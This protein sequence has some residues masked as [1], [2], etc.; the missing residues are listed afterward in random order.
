MGSMVH[1]APGAAPFDTNRACCRI[2]ADAFHWRKIDYQAAV[3]GAQARAIVSAAADRQ[4]Q[5]LLACKVDGGDYI[6]DIHAAH[7]QRGM[8]INH[9]VV[10]LACLLVG[11]IARTEQGATQMSCQFLDRLL[12]QSGCD[13]L[14][15]HW[16]HLLHSLFFILPS[17]WSRNGLQVRSG[18]TT[19]ITRI[20]CVL[21]A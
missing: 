3:A 13:L 2:D 7:E 8:L 4:C 17:S 5:S 16:G 14:L 12:F 10:D 20:R 18:E 9:S 11:G 1:V 21:S 15:F 6:G 19:G